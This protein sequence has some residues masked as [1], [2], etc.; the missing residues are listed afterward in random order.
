VWADQRGVSASVSGTGECR[1]VREGGS[2]SVSG[3]VGTV[4]VSGRG[5]CGCV[6]ERGECEHV[7]EGGSEC[8]MGGTVG[9]SGRGEKG[10][11]RVGVSGSC[12]RGAFMAMSGRVDQ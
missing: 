6:R 5:A 12:N 2:M 3:R 10:R 9:V 11:V 1:R 4:G 7:R 8:V